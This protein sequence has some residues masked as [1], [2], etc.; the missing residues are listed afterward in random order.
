MNQAAASHVIV[1]STSITAVANDTADVNVALTRS[2]L[3]APKFWPAT[4]PTANPSA[5]TGRK[6][7]CR[8]R[9]PMPKPAWAAAPN[10][11]LTT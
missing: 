7:A 6:L 1:D 3:R 11:R 2:P 4:G 9:W 10:G 8:M 5:T